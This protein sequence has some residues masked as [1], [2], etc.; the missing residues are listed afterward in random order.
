MRVC[1]TCNVEKPDPQFRLL[2]RGRRKTCLEC[3]KGGAI[4]VKARNASPAQQKESAPE[5][6]KLNGHLEVAAGL[7]F[8]ASIEDVCADAADQ[9]RQ[10][11]IEQDREDDD[12]QVYTHTVSLAP[13]EARQ[14]VDWITER[15]VYP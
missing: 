2:G 5:P 15:V 10:L 14:L 3:E 12:G 11:I 7:G 9:R 8:R 13:H 6:V 4:S 1:D